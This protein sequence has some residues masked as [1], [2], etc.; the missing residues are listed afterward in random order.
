MSDFNYVYDVLNGD[1]DGDLDEINAILENTEPGTGFW[2]DCLEAH[3][4][5]ERRTFAAYGRKKRSL[6]TR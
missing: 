3:D 5:I 4:K 6:I 1:I 2:G